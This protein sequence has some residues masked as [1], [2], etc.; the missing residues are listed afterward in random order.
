MSPIPFSRP[1]DEFE[2]KT[3]YLKGLFSTNSTT[4]KTPTQLREDIARVLQGDAIEFE[5]YGAVFFCEYQ[6]SIDK[7][8][9]S[10]CSGEKS[11]QSMAITFEV[12][13]VKVAVFG[14]FGVLFKRI[15][16]D[17]SVYKNLCSQ[18]LSQLDL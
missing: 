9:G 16:G 6:P 4:K 5:N 13:I 2:I 18:I 12:H 10:D 14:Q 3:V 7:S 1:L 15:Q 11:P 17:I 8:E